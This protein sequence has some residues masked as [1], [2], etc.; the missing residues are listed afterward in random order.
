MMPKTITQGVLVCLALLACGGGCVQPARPGAIKPGARRV[1]PEPPSPPCIRYLGSIQTEQSVHRSGSPA[2]GLGE[3]IFG[4]KDLGVLLA[5]S[6]VAVSTDGR[7]YVADSGAGVIHAFNFAKGEYRQFG[8]IG[9][10]Q[11]LQRPVGLAL[12]DQYVYVVD[13]QLH[14]VC[15]FRRTGEF[16]FSFGASDLS[17]PAGIAYHA[18]R[19]EVYVSDAAAHRLMVF[20]PS[21]A[22]LR[23][24]GSR[25]IGPGQ[26]NYPTH[27]WI[28]QEGRLFIS[29][30]LNYRIQ[31]LL[32]DQITFTFFGEH[33]D[34]PGY[35]GHPGGVATD[36]FGHIYVTDRQFENVQV[37]DSQGQILMAFGQEGSGDGEFWLPSGLYIDERNRIYV[38]DTF[39]KRIQVFEFMRNPGYEN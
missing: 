23:A 39:N 12:A 28:D 36:R 15:V 13:S 3:L 8:S 4:R 2:A 31:I 11:S 35:F 26:F 9:P 17:R 5:P 18:G 34:R 27:L 30:T 16:L 20:S 10:G 24:I 19:R 14:V 1:W 6:A 37:F 33:G 32:P 21:G 7:L 38:A 22:F 29:D 25:G